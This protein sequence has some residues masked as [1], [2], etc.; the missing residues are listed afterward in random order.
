MVGNR[1]HY[2]V[3]RERARAM[4]RNPTP[5]EAELWKRLRDGRLGGQHFA[6]QFVVGEFIVDFYCHAAGLAV[7]LDGQ[8]HAD[9]RERDAERDAYLGER[10]LRVV[11]FPNERVLGDIYGVLREIREAVEDSP[12]RLRRRPSL[13]REGAPQT[14][15]EDDERQRD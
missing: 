9:Q 7:E 6:R 4:R 5:A 14:A 13:E 8:V 12:R 3:L 1:E 11:R 15:R 10:G 2:L